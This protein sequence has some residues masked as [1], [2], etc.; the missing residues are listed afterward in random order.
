MFNFLT[1]RINNSEGII[2][3]NQIIFSYRKF[4]FKF[5]KYFKLFMLLHKFCSEN[6]YVD[7]KI[8]RN[9]S[10]FIYWVLLYE[11]Y[12]KDRIQ[13]F[14]FT[15]HLQFNPLGNFPSCYSSQPSNSNSPSLPR[16]FKFPEDLL[17]ETRRPQVGRGSV[18]SFRPSFI[19][20]LIQ[21]GVVPRDALPV[22]PG[23]S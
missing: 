20:R 18:R 19:P 11:N 6:Y 17:M 10:L 12:L 13:N 14:T 23:L 15:F 22:N 16:T 2:I 7:K 9:K 4:N 21:T 8:E 3:F 1:L 5:D